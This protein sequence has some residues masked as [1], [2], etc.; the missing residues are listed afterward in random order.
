M[1]DIYKN[2]TYLCY[3]NNARQTL[4]FENNILP[5]QTHTTMKNYN[6][7]AVTKYR[8]LILNDSSNSINFINTVFDG[9]GELD[10]SKGIVKVSVKKQQTPK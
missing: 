4:D 7:A 3:T 8:R 9:S 2:N 1:F 10:E 6:Y 5:L